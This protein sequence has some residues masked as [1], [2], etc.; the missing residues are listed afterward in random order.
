MQSSSVAARDI[1]S[2][3]V[4]ILKE[5][6]KFPTKCISEARLHRALAGVPAAHLES[7]DVAQVLVDYI[8]E[9]GRF[10]DDV[11]PPW[12]FK[13]GR[14]TLRLRNTKVS[15]KYIGKIIDNVGSELTELDVSGTFQVDDATVAYVLEKCRKLTSLNIRNCRK[16]TDK[17]LE[18]IVAKGNSL[19]DLDIGGNVNISYKGV[20]GLVSSKKMSSLRELNLSG[21]PIQ[22]DTLALI[23]RS[24]NKLTSFGIGFADIGESA[25]RDFIST[26]GHQL[27]KLGLHWMCSTTNCMFDQL[28]ADFIFDFLPRTCPL[29]SELDICGQKNINAP[30][31]Q[32]FLDAKLSQ[33]ESSPGQWVPLRILKAKFIGSTKALVEQ[34]LLGSHPYLKL[35]A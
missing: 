31:L 20:I 15:G 30:S 35:E 19:V 17:S 25:L 27:E 33:S 12:L 2:L 13:A 4:T 6:A 28:T 7:Y 34:I 10:T 5:I 32:Q 29:L 16:I 11:L 26:R 14:T 23:S 21:L 8:T 9:A 18:V 24:G 1:P 3:T 22:A